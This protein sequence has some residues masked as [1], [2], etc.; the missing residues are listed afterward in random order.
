MTQSELVTA[1]QKQLNTGV[2]QSA[3]SDWEAARKRLHGELIVSLCTILEV[4]ANTLLDVRN[5]HLSTKVDRLLESL[6][7]KPKRDQGELIKRFLQI[8]NEE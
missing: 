6:A 3:V 5:P 8:L 2:G 7:K 4:D 1:L